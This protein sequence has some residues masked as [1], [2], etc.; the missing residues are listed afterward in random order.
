MAPRRKSLKEIAE[1][2]ECGKRMFDVINQAIVDFGPWQL[3]S[4]WLAF[5]LEDGTCNRDVYDSLV[6]A[7]RFTDEHTHCYYSFRAALSGL[8]ARD[9]E[10][11]LDFH[12]Q[13]RNV[14]LSQSDPNAVPIMS[15][16]AG[17]VFRAAQQGRLP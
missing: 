14:R 11:F 10:I 12:R 2:A 9:C 6:T 8:S 16:G 17:D 4:S 7:K 3:K 1:L 13:A 15:F 5:K